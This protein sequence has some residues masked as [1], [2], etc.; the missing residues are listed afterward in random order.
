MVKIS[1][2]TLGPCK[3]AFGVAQIDIFPYFFETI[4]LREQENI[5]NGRDFSQITK[6]FAL[7]SPIYIYIYT[8][9]ILSF[10]KV[11]SHDFFKLKATKQALEKHRLF[12]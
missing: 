9:I 7:C 10:S 3:S 8:F 4:I 11:Y 12:C 2:G 1:T 6:S 5:F